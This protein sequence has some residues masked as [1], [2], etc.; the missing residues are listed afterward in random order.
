MNRISTISIAK[1][2][3]LAASLMGGTALA[4]STQVIFY[5]DFEG[6]VLE[7]SVDESTGDVTSS[8]GQP[9]AMRATAS[10]PSW[11]VV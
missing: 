3:G 6:A 1:A 2:A 8:T 10:I 4:Q 11:S 9:M 5:E 7:D